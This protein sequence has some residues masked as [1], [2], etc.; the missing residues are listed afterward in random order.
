MII[1][2]KGKLMDINFKKQ[3]INDY[4]VSSDDFKDKSNI[5]T[6][7]KADES[8]LFY[9]KAPFAAICTGGKVFMRSENPA[10]INKLRKNFKEYPG[11]W[12]AE[13]AILGF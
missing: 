10:L 3:I 11:A 7:N 5:F 12:F 9:N 13:I 6:V 4:Q 2:F 8:F 1:N